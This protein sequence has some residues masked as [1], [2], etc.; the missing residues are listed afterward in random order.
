MP[1]EERSMHTVA[2]PPVRRCGRCKFAISSN[3]PAQTLSAAS[4]ALTDHTHSAW[5]EKSLAAIRRRNSICANPTPNVIL[6]IL[7]GPSHRQPNSSRV[8]NCADE[9]MSAEQLFQA[10]A[11]VRVVFLA[12]FLGFLSCARLLRRA[13]IIFT[14][15][16]F[17][18]S[19]SS[20]GR[21][22]PF[23][24]APTSFFTAAS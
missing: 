17:A 1:Q 4:A 2:I 20:S 7:V 16:V 18:G 23:R 3:R 22:F 15:L 8:S 9:W 19:G 12:A 6:R 24:F 14:T 11:F 21:A 10:A 13:S 5:S